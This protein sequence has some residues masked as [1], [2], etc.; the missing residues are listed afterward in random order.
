VPESL[1]LVR[2]AKAGD[3]SKWDGDDRYRP[4]TKKG[5]R[6]AQQV[7]DR[8]G[9]LLVPSSGLRLV[10]SPYVRCRQTIEP[11]STR[12]DLAIEDD[13]RLA[14]GFRLDGALELVATLP[15]GSVMCSH[16]DVIPDVIAAL[17][18]RGADMLSDPDWR[19]GSVWVLD[20]HDGDVIGATCWPPP[21]DD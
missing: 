11:L 14:E 6:Q 9:E 17:Q 18:R 10:S 5:W 21:S 7:C 16:G 13:D 12:F 1:F 8:I 20:R 15:H 4:L 3:R 19:K 2:H